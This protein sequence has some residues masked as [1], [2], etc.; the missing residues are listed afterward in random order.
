MSFNLGEVVKA[1]FVSG[2]SE[3]TI[4]PTTLKTMYG[5]LKSRRVLLGFVRYVAFPT[6]RTL[7]WCVSH[8]PTAWQARCQK[9]IPLLYVIR[10]HDGPRVGTPIPEDFELT[11]LT[12]EKTTSG[13]LLSQHELVVVNCG[14]L[15]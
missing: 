10:A 14:S 9:A 13:Q 1:L 4:T 5:E 6:G 15:T 2:H 11:F 12:G 8:L 7:A 3:R